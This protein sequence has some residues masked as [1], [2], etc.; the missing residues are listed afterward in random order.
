MNLKIHGKNTEKFKDF[1]V[2]NFKTKMTLSAIATLM[3]LGTSTLARWQ[4]NKFYTKQKAE[5]EDLDEKELNDR[6]KKLKLKYAIG[7][8]FRKAKTLNKI[9]AICVYLERGESMK[10]KENTHEDIYNILEETARTAE[11]NVINFID[12]L[13]SGAEKIKESN[14]E[15]C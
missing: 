1:V 14:L 9:L 13:V 8:L 5:L 15:Q 4:D 11:L 12:Q 10:T 3:D 7:L 2:L 6:V